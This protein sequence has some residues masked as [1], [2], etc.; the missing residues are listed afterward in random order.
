VSFD[1][2]TACEQSD[3]FVDEI[4]YEIKGI[5]QFP[6]CNAPF[7]SRTAEKK[8]FDGYKVY[9]RNCFT[10]LAE[11]DLQNLVITGCGEVIRDQNQLEKLQKKSG[12]GFKILIVCNNIG[13]PNTQSGVKFVSI[14]S[15]INSVSQFEYL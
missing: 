8:F 5:R 4:K 12:E 15:F 3:R 9:F 7:K 14:E 10:S 13:M 11:E 6:T 1:W 2:I